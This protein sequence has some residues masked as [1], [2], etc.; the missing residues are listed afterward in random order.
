[1]LVLK[2]LGE[3]TMPGV[4]KE[5]SHGLIR[6]DLQRKKSLKEEPRLMVLAM[7]LFVLQTVKTVSRPGLEETRPLE[8]RLL[9]VRERTT[10]EE[11]EDG[12]KTSAV[13]NQLLGISNGDKRETPRAELSLTPKDMETLVVTPMTKDQV[14][15]PKDVVD[16]L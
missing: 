2:T 8:Q 4:R 7:E 1:M 12:R 9:T 6:T 11:Q 5:E 10:G 14:V 3:T 16:P 13:E 15:T